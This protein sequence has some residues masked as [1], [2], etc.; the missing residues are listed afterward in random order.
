[1]DTI[2]WTKDHPEAKYSTYTGIDKDG[3]VYHQ[4]ANVITVTLPDGRKGVGWSPAGAFLAAKSQS[5][6]GGGKE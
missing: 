6:S 5:P 4:T 2:I 3:N 1:M